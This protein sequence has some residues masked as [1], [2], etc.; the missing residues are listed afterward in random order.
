MKAEDM[1]IVRQCLSRISET[2]VT[3]LEAA[4]AIKTVAQAFRQISDGFFAL[5]DL[6]IEITTDEATKEGR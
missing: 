6:F 5:G 2:G 4:I 1:E 3:A